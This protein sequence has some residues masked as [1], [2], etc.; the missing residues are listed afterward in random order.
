MNMPAFLI[1]G[2]VLE[3]PRTVLRLACGACGHEARWPRARALDAFGPGATPP[4]V[5]ARLV[6]S[7]CGE[8]RRVN[9]CV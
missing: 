1:L 5:R 6:C 2:H 3:D 9:A 7:R 8:R 4:Q